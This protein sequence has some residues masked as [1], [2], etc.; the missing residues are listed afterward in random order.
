MKKFLVSTALLTI[1]VFCFSYVSFADTIGNNTKH[2]MN[3]V[4][5]TLADTA[6]GAKNAITNT[7]NAVANGANNA[8]NTVADTSKNIAN[9]AKNVTNSMAATLSNTGN[10]GYTAEKTATDTTAM[11]MSTTSWTWIILGIFG[12]VIVGLV[13]FYG[14]QYEHKNY[15]ND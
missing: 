5:N 11:G 13:W 4:G 14:A 7:K 12:A 8:K 9:G 2:A 15:D 10:N 3:A 6:T 1:L